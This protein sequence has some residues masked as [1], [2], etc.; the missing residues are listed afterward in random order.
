MLIVQ[1]IDAS[2]HTLHTPDQLYVWFLSVCLNKAHL[3]QDV[4]PVTTSMNP[5]TATRTDQ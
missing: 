4:L 5:H 3:H 2:Q 1:M